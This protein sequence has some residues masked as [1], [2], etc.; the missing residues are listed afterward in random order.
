[1]SLELKVRSRDRLQIPIMLKLTYAAVTSLHLKAYVG[2]SGPDAYLTRNCAYSS[3]ALLSHLVPFL[4]Y[5][6]GN[7]GRKN[8]QLRPAAIVITPSIS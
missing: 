4:E 8:R 3:S 1:M 6:C 5:W 7:C 2:A